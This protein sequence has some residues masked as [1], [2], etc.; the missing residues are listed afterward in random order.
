SPASGEKIECETLVVGGNYNSG[1][2]K[3]WSQLVFAGLIAMAGIS[4]GIASAPDLVAHVRRAA[5]LRPLSVW[6]RREVLFGPYYASLRAIRR[7]LPETASIAIV[8]A[9]ESDFVS[10]IFANTY[11]YPRSSILYASFS[12]WETHRIEGAVRF[13]PRPMTIVWLN[14]DVTQEARIMTPDAIRQELAGP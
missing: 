5:E 1:V 10:G 8:V 7:T 12:D 6:R 3:A 13:R 9:D 4:G 14:D 11:L 2:R